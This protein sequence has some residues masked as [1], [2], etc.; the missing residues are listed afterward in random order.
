MILQKRSSPKVKTVYYSDEENDEFSGIR[1]NTIRI[2]G[3]FPFLHRNPL[4]NFAALLVYRGIMTPIAFLHCKLRFGLR[5]VGREK[6]RAA[7]KS[8]YFLYGNHTLLAG[9][10]YLPSLVSFPRRTYVVVNADNLSTPGTRNWVQMSGALPLPNESSGAR[11]FLKALRKRIGQGFCVTVYP[12][13]HIWPYYT[14][15]RAFGSGSFLYPV[16]LNVPVFCTTTTFQKKRIG[17]TPRVTVY[18]DG[19]FLPDPALPVKDREREL[20]ERVRETM[21]GRAENSTYSPIRYV[22]A[23]ENSPEVKR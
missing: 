21:R 20:C 9:D 8:G 4:W 23:G 5:I 22:R 10:A 16:R 7:K 14:G 18:V 3:D 1:K 12:E 2:G 19:P 17:R 11:P 15:I 6:L 13:A